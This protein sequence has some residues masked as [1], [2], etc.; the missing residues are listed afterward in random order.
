MRYALE[1]A[2]IEAAGM[3]RASARERANSTRECAELLIKP[4]R[5]VRTCLLRRTEA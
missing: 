3:I 1:R 2:C 5:R 4:L